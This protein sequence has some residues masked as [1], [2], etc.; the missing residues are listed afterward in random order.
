MRAIV[1]FACGPYRLGQCRLMKSLFETGYSESLVFF[2][3]EAKLGC[4]RHTEA[5]YAFKPMVFQK[6]WVA[7][8]TTLLWV[9]ASVWALKDITPL[10][11]LIER[12]GHLLFLNNT[13]ELKSAQWTSDAC[14]AGFAMTRDEALNVDQTMGAVM[15]LDLTKPDSQKFL[16]VW[17][18]KS[19]DGFSF[20]GSWT[21]RHHE[22]S[23]DPRCSGHRHDQANASIIAHQ[24]G[25]K[26][27]EA[28]GLFSYWEDPKQP[29]PDSILV[30]QHL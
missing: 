22:V 23:L 14:L 25:W 26:L 28:T 12:Y 5:P 10:F 8:Y 13:S 17:L 11:D 1:N 27:T 15:G 2:T 30:L 6:A 19:K 24:L 3:N 7:G 16:E 18:E 4:A 9:D 21:N 20:P 29:K